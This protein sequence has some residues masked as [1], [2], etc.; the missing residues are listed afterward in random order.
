MALIVGVHGIAQEL[1]GQAILRNEWLPPLR[2]GVAAVRLPTPELSLE[3]AF[4]GGLFRPAGEVRGAGEI[5]YGKSDITADEA[6]LVTLLW[7][8][9]ARVDDTVPAPEAELRS[10]PNA[11]Q[12]AL[13]VL[14][15]SR[16]FAGMAEN[17][18]LGALKQ[19]TRYLRELEIREGA[20]NSVHSIVTEETRVIIGHSLGSVVVYEALG[21]FADDPRWRNVRTLVT[22]GSPLGIPNL[23]FD[24]LQPSPVNGIGQWPGRIQHWTNISD[25]GDVVALQ[26]SLGPL[27]P[28]AVTDIRIHN[29][30]TAHNISPYLSA[31]ET[32]LAIAYGLR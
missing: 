23:I 13:R 17:A 25:D 30:A 14:A 11:V 29:G 26:K 5:H 15:R 19:V 8:E 7:K 2:D 10:T 9:A 18:F 28:G 6:A 21:R 32:G 27:F 16:F 1:K 31:A 12:T 24:R 22:L 20:Q 4:Y 3:C